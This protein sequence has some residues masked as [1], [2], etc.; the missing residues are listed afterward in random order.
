MEKKHDLIFCPQCGAKLDGDEII[1]P[2]CGYK[3]AEVKPMNQTV[4]PEVPPPP[5]EKPLNTVPPP[6]I[7]KPITL[8]V[9]LLDNYQ[10]PLPGYIPQKPKKKGMGAGWIILII[11]LCL[12]VLG[13]GTVAFLQ[14]NGNINMEVLK[15]IV[16]SKEQP[17]QSKACIKDPIRYYVVQS[18]AIVNSK[19]TAIVS[20]IV[21]SKT[22]YNNEEGAKNQFK[23]AIMVKYPKLWNLFSGN[24]IVNKYNSLSDAESAH[25]SLIKTYDAKNYIIN[26][27]NFGY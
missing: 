7:T 22:P 2:A 24:I 12:I 25:S 13:G 26:T 15:N 6:V 16:P 10:Q 5:E 19:W 18:F 20:D 11:L 27:V 8:P 17:D 3:L 9:I 14:Y 21:V 1:C 4:A 23:K